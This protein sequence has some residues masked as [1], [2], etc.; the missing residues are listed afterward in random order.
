MPAEF[1]AVA[2]VFL[3]VIDLLRTKAA[4]EFQTKSKTF[5]LRIPPS[6]SQVFH[7]YPTSLEFSDTPEV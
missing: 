6:N 4:F 1:S 5:T 3:V 7:F 2:A